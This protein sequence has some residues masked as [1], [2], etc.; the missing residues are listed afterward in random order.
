MSR[1]QKLENWLTS[2]KQKDQAEL[3]KEKQE[4]AKSLAGLKKSQIL[5]EEPK[6]YTLWTR[7]KKALMGF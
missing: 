1:L 4:F 3:E 5:D 6:K 2:E 7:I